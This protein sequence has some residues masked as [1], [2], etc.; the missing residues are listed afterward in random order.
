[1]VGKNETAAAAAPLPP[2][3]E[4]AKSRVTAL[5]GFKRLP[6]HKP[7]SFE[8][9]LLKNITSR[10]LSFRYNYRRLDDYDDDDDDDDDED[11]ASPQNNNYVEFE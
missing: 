7:S 1:M 3:W 6:H 9:I 8:V 4:I 10:P 5:A 11:F 2:P